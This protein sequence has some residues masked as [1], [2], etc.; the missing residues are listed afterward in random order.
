MRRNR[1]LDQDSKCTHV[2]PLRDDDSTKRI[3]SGA[4]APV[5]SFWPEIAFTFSFDSGMGFVNSMDYMGKGRIPAEQRR[6]VQRFV[7]VMTTIVKSHGLKESTFVT[8][9][10]PNKM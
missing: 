3:V 1:L 5:F 10:S 7:L 9:A 2:S 4:L 8:I 6:S